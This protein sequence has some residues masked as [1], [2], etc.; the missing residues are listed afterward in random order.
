MNTDKPDLLEAAKMLLGYS[1][2]SDTVEGVRKYNQ[3][4]RD[5][6]DAIAAE[7]SRRAAE[8]EPQCSGWDCARGK[9][10]PACDGKNEPDLR[11]EN[12]ALKKELEESGR[13]YFKSKKELSRIATEQSNRAEKAESDRK[14]AEDP[15]SLDNPV[16][17]IEFIRELDAA[18]KST[19]EDQ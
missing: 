17:H 6:R 19:G 16:D 11:A 12:E 4:E 7:E 8:P 1:T 13:M 18:L 2:G 3:A 5:L 9:D 10:C 15:V 14:A